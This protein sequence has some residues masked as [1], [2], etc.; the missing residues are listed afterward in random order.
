[1]EQL[2]PIQTAAIEELIEEP[3]SRLRLHRLID[4]IECD[5][6]D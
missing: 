4:R 1:M 6:G 3:G 2:A 5:V